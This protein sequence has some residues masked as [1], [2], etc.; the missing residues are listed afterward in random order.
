MASNNL[1]NRGTTKVYNCIENYVN[2]NVQDV[3]I[4]YVDNL[5]FYR[6]IK[7]NF[8]LDPIRY[9]NIEKVKDLYRLYC[10]IIPGMY[11]WRERKIF[12]KEEKKYDFSLLL[13]ELL[14]SKSITQGYKTIADWIK[15]GLPHYLEKILCQLCNITYTESEHKKY[16][17]I[18]EQ[19]HQKYNDLNVLY[20]II[21]AE[22]INIT[23]SIL[24]AIFNY[25]KEDILEITFEEKQKGF[26]IQLL[27]HNFLGGF[28]FSSLFSN[29][30]WTNFFSKH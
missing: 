16:F 9:N 20:A 25:N 14:H 6:C 26:Y 23:K 13:A 1:L 24:K 22:N 7:D 17:I 18:W 30:I 29:F 10:E 19:V 8:P 28:I 27:I 4:S 5:E 15:E 11:K 12:I 2:I 21:F 3:P